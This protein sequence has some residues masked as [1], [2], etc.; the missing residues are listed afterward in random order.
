VDQAAKDWTKARLMKKSRENMNP[1]EGDAE[2]FKDAE[3]MQETANAIRPG[4]DALQWA[5]N[6]DRLMFQRK[7]KREKLAD[8]KKGGSLEAED[9]SDEPDASVVN[10]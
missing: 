7:P 5:A 3:K 8:K 2:D 1:Y 4:E 10:A 6:R 9:P